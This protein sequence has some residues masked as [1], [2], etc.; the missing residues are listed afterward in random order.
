MIEKSDG[1][2]DLP[3]H[4]P[5]FMLPGEAV[6]YPTNCV[7]MIEESYAEFVADTS[8]NIVDRVEFCWHRELGGFRSDH[9]DKLRNTLGLELFENAC[10]LSSSSAYN[11]EQHALVAIWLGEMLFYCSESDTTR[12]VFARCIE[13]YSGSNMLVLSA[14]RL[15]ASELLHRA[16][17]EGDEFAAKRFAVISDRLRTALLSNITTNIDNSPFS[18]LASYAASSVHSPLSDQYRGAILDMLKHRHAELWARS[19]RAATLLILQ[20]AAVSDKSGDILKALELSQSEMLNVLTEKP[21]WSSSSEWARYFAG[22]RIMRGREGLLRPMH[23][24]KWQNESP[25][26]AHLLSTV[27]EQGQAIH[28]NKVSSKPP[29]PKP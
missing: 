9:L 21:S 8:S 15:Q 12:D 28:T 11:D 20:H 6:L 29:T 14:M 17:K 2:A 23:I 10:K 7:S 22:F 26:A 1:Q 5:S 19:D 13:K 4:A 24:G 16:K 18:F 3:F 25:F 27:R